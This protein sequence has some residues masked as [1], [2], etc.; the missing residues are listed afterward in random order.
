MKHA[1]KE[2]TG[3]RAMPRIFPLTLAAGNIAG[4][5]DFRRY[6]RSGVTYH[7]AREVVNARMAE[8]ARP[9][10]LVDAALGKRW[11]ISADVH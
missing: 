8:H 10:S 11:M 9:I 2:T 6:C 5:I 1:T 3:Q 7:R 4:E